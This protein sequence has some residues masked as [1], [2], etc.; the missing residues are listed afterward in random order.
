MYEKD[1][2]KRISE[3]TGLKDE[4][5]INAYINFLRAT[6]YNE[7]IIFLG[8]VECDFYIQLRDK[9]DLKTK[10]LEKIMCEEIANHKVPS[11]TKTPMNLEA[12][13]LTD[14]YLCL[15]IDKGLISKPRQFG[16]FPAEYPVLLGYNYFNDPEIYEVTETKSRRLK[17]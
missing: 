11:G 1:F 16:G 6:D 14:Y 17:I 7:E 13:R 10:K 2:L 8:N 3:K 12:N 5:E 9:A 15:F 4:D